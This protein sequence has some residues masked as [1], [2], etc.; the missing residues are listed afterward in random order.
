MK[1]TEINEGIQ[2]QID[3][4]NRQL[5]KLEENNSQDVQKVKDEY[6]RLFI[7][8]TENENEIKKIEF[9]LNTRKGYTSLANT[10]NLGMKIK[11]SLNNSNSTNNLNN[12]NSGENYNMNSNNINI[13]NSIPEISDSVI[14]KDAIL[15]NELYKLILN[16]V[17]GKPNLKKQNQQLNHDSFLK[18]VFSSIKKLETKVLTSIGDLMFFEKT[19]KVVFDK[20]CSNKRDINR[21]HNFN[22]GLKLIEMSI[23]IYLF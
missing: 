16:I 18:S 17:D 3:S 8:I 20:Y 12:L 1:Q 19:D 11:N 4:M 9:I 6:K 2:N 23:F 7:D 10:N 15:L 21:N 22:E 14:S 5:K 13:I